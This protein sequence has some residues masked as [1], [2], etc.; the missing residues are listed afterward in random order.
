MYRIPVFS[1]GVVKLKEPMISALLFNFWLSL[2]LNFISGTYAASCNGNPAFCEKRFNEITYP[3]THNSQSFIPFLNLPFD[4]SFPSI[5]WFQEVA[6]VIN[7]NVND[8]DLNLMKQLEDGIRA[9]KLRVM[10]DHHRT[11][12]CHGMSFHLKGQI[13]SKLCEKL[14]FELVRQ[15]CKS[16]VHA[17]EPCF[18]DPAARPLAEV[19]LQLRS[20][21]ISHPR[22]VITLFIEDD[23]E[24]I[25]NLT[26]A[27]E[28]SGTSSYL[29]QQDVNLPWPYLKDLI[30]KDKRLV[31]FV[32]SSLDDGRVELGN[33]RY[34][35]SFSE[36]VWSSRYHFE[37][38][39][40]L[41]HDEP[42][43]SDLTGQAFTDRNKSP[44]NKLW[45]LQHFITPAIAGNPNY[46]LEVNK[47]KPL[48]GRVERY[49]KLLGTNPNFIWVDFYELPVNEPGYLE[50]VKILNQGF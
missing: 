23:T 22:E 5:P 3:T 14:P 33:S 12:T 31:I 35:N 43:S 8:Q 11:Y 9:M 25:E 29:Y 13:E 39:D 37:S 7:I 44:Q 30:E 47:L 17:T 20:F 16:E 21:L 18:I 34:F 10:V 48:K 1:R 19:L 41:I 15:T 27:V 24:S 32:H 42:K 45:V 38:V 40:D 50:E 6:S 28:E 49:R 4:L 36:F 2:G 26:S 46:A